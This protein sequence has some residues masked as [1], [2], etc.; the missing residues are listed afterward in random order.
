MCIQERHFAVHFVNRVLLK[1]WGNV[2]E[3]AD[4]HLKPN[5]FICVSGCLASFTKADG[6]GNFRLYYEVHHFFY[7]LFMLGMFFEMSELLFWSLKLDWSDNM[8]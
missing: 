6:N 4:E 1:M 2:G 7:P 3:F 5:H 8:V